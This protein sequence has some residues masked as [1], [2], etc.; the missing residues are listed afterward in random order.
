[1]RILLSTLRIALALGVT[2][3][4]LPLA[5]QDASD[6]AAYR[7]LTQTPIGALAP[8]ASAS[9]TGVARRGVAFTARYGLMS[10]SDDKFIHNVGVTAELPVGPGRLGVTGG[11]YNP[12]C[13]NDTCPGHFMAGASYSGSLVSAALGRPSSRG[14]VNV[15]LDL[16]VGVAKP[17][18]GTLLAAAASVPLSLVPD[19]HTVRIFPFVAPGLGVGHGPV[20]GRNEDGLRGTFAAGVGLLGWEGR[21]G[22]TAALSRVFLKDGNWLAGIGL[23]WNGGPRLP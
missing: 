19:G 13:G 7:A 6:S 22:M 4:A 11:Y 17:S 1:M 12:V 14:S 16:S 20:N 2:T 9:L 15:G 23:T 18:D 21:F 3:N 5:A 8:W 10:Y